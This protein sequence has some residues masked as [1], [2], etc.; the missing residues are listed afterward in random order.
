MSN[1]FIFYVK[2]GLEHVLD[3]AAYDHILFLAAL[4]IPFT[5]IRWKDVVLL[6]T[7]FTFVNLLSHL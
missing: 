6:A 4:S 7:I 2:L 3:F 5:F 1:D